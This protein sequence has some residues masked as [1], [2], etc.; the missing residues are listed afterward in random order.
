M[1]VKVKRVYNDE[2]RPLAG[3]YTRVKVAGYTVAAFAVGCVREGE[4][5]R[6]ETHGPLVP[7]PWAYAFPLASVIDNYGGTAAVMARERAAG[8]VIDAKLGD[9]LIVEGRGY[10][11]VKGSNS[12]NITLVPER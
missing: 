10:V 5:G 12:D 2:M 8:N 11:I 7:G 9:V 1:R 6:K 3:D 4:S